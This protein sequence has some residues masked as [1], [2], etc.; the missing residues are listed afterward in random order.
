[1]RSIET[2]RLM[3]L[4]N[5]NDSRPKICEC[6]PRRQ[7]VN[8]IKM[9]FEA[10]TSDSKVWPTYN[11][12]LLL[13]YRVRVQLSKFSHNLDSF[14][15]R[16]NQVTAYT[17]PFRQIYDYKTHIVI[18]LGACAVLLAACRAGALMWNITLGVTWKTT[19]GSLT[20]ISSDDREGATQ[21]QITKMSEAFW[22]E[23]LKVFSI[24]CFGSETSMGGM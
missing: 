9:S 15:R 19:I 20:H 10:V 12:K 4:D 22:V 2:I 6:S 11:I 1:M 5:V 21:I 14:V 7:Q 18:K 8:K 17:L 3:M 16:R 23:Q 13:R 24:N